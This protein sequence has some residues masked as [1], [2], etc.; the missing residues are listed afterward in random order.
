MPGPWYHNGYM[1]II[2]IFHNGPNRPSFPPNAFGRPELH[3]CCGHTQ[4]RTV[5]R[6]IDLNEHHRDWHRKKILLFPPGTSSK[7]IDTF[8]PY[9]ID[10][11]PD[12]SGVRPSWVNVEYIALPL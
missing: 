2:G 3:P 1:A 4:F 11:V 7:I 10:R 12:C 5:K 9:S 6:D 8:T